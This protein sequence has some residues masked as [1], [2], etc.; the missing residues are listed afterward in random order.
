M[1]REVKEEEVDIWRAGNRNGRRILAEVDK[2]EER[3]KKKQRKKKKRERRWK[4]VFSLA[5]LS[6]FESMQFWEQSHIVV[7][8]E[9]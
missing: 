1:G 5:S 7:V 6:A 3:K 9:H 4:Q 8:S 2:T